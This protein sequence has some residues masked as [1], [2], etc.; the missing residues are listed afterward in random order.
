MLDIEKGWGDEGVKRYIFLNMEEEENWQDVVTSDR[1]W[2][3]QEEK[4][5]QCDKY[6]LV[7]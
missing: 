5:F 4:N 7:S 2:D 6:L 3:T 1:T